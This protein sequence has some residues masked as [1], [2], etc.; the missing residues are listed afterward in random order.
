MCGESLLTFLAF[1]VDC[2]FGTIVLVGLPVVGKDCLHSVL[3]C[4][5][6]L[7]LVFNIWTFGVFNPVLKA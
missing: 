3:P 1:V 6:L 7:G 5:C 2:S 4:G